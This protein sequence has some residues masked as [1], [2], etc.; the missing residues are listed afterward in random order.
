MGTLLQPLSQRFRP[1]PD[2]ERVTVRLAK[3]QIDPAKEGGWMYS[4]LAQVYEK[5]NDR[6]MIFHQGGAKKTIRER[7]NSGRV[8]I[9]DGH[10]WDRTSDS[11]VGLVMSAEEKPDGLYYRGFLSKTEG[12]LVQKM[13]EGIIDENSL[14]LYV[15]RE[16]TAEVDISEV[17]EMARTWVS[18][19]SSGKAIVRDIK[20]WVWL[21]IGLLPAS[22]QG[23]PC[24]IDP[25]RVVPYQD[26]PL[27]SASTAWDPEGA[28]RR[29]EAWA[30]DPRTGATNYARLASAYL[31]RGRGE[32]RPGFLG[33]IAD[34]VD[35]ELVVVPAALESA[36]LE[37]EDLLEKDPL[38][39]ASAART[40][41]RYEGRMRADLTAAQELPDH[42][43]SSNAPEPDARAARPATPPAALGASG[44]SPESP[45]RPEQPPA[46]PLADGGADR[47][48]RLRSL[49]MEL[50]EL[51]LPGGATDVS[52]RAGDQLSQ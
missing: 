21:S 19:S 24:L 49:R 51:D 52:D 28:A 4:A 41:G 8:K 15:L 11:T 32:G 34:V 7:V 14:V 38:S 50:L 18:M 44:D 20:E 23:I 22:S 45:A 43:P 9:E 31:G 40:I 17:P 39:L 6:L 37:L 25:P 36:Y 5:V 16:G 10:P 30:H 46:G 48:A 35:G 42:L 27:A 26:L 2:P 47:A 12:D 29:V 33:P 13:S 3:L 1:N